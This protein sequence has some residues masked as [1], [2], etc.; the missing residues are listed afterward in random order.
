[1]SIALLRALSGFYEFHFPIFFSP[2]TG[3][4]FWGTLNRLIL[5]LAKNNNPYFVISIAWIVVRILAH[6]DIAA[7][8][9]QCRREQECQHLQNL[10]EAQDVLQQAQDEQ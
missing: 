9:S 7:S 10:Q 3:E 2:A 5:N 6:F 4:G 8:M 1:M